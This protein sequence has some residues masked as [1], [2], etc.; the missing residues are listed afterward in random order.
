MKKCLQNTSKNDHIRSCF[1][2]KIHETEALEC[3]S[4]SSAASE[5]PTAFNKNYVRVPE[6]HLGV[7]SRHL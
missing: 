5:R 1:I 7:N 6:R 2:L 4:I 3:P